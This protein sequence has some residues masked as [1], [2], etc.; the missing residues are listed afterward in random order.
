MTDYLNTLNK[1]QRIAAEH[2]DGPLLV[3]AG[4]GSG[5]TY[6]MTIRMKHLVEFHKINPASILGIT[7]TVKAANEMKERAIK[8]I[9]PKGAYIN[10]STFH[11]MCVKILRKDIHFLKESK[12]NKGRGY[13]SSFSILDPKDQL[14]I[15]KECMNELEI[16][17]KEYAPSAFLGYISTFKNELMNPDILE[18]CIRYADNPFATHFPHPPYIDIHKSVLMAQKVPPFIRNLVLAVYRRYMRKLVMMNSMDFDDL[19]MLTVRLFI[20]IPE[21]LGSY[22]DKFKYIMVDEYQDS[23]HAQY[24]LVKLLA[25]KHRNI[26]VVGDD[27]QCLIPSTKVNTPNGMVHIDQIKVGDLVEA[28]RGEF[29]TSFEK[30]TAVKMKEYGGNIIQVKTK[31]G[32]IVKGTPDHR[33]FSTFVTNKNDVYVVLFENENGYN[34]GTFNLEELKNLNTKRIFI[35]EVCSS[36]GEATYKSRKYENKSIESIVAETSLDLEYPHY[37]PKFYNG[38]PV[39][40]A[41]VQLASSMEENEIKHTY[42]LV[43]ALGKKTSDQLFSDYKSLQEAVSELASKQELYVQEKIVIDRKRLYFTPLS[44]LRKGMWIAVQTENGVVID[45][46]VDVMSKRYKGLVYDL[47]VANVHN[48]FANGVLVH[49]CIYGFRNA[50]LRNIL[51]F[52]KDYK[53]A[54]TVMLERNYRST[55]KILDRANKVISFNKHQRKKKLWTDKKGGDE[56]EYKV[57][58]DNY[59]EAEAIAEEIRKS[60]PYREYKD[61]AVLYRLNAQSRVLEEIFMRNGIPYTLVGSINFYDRREIKDVVSYLKVIVN[62]ADDMSLKRI[63]NVPKRG[64][65]K[66]TLEKIEKFASEENLT[67]WDA[68]VNAK[69][70]L[71]GNVTN[72]IA[73]FVQLISDLRDSSEVMGV[74]MIVDE[75]LESTGYKK[76]LELQ[77]TQ[78]AED[79]IENLNE[80]FNVAWEHQQEDED[81]SIISFLEKLSLSGAQESKDAEDDKQIEKDA[82]RLM[83]VHASKGLEFPVVFGIGMEENML[84]YYKAIAEDENVE[85]E[86]R[87]CYVLATRAKERLVFL[88]AKERR[89][90]NDIQ[91]NDPSRFLKE[92]GFEESET[93]GKKFVLPW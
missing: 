62:P 8:L 66:T 2:K 20:E 83:T 39:V 25:A 24:I 55:Q 51:E 87:L 52:E 14:N 12:K 33:T 75:V 7:F 13:D 72:K 82:V 43:S 78:E 1:D 29:G 45:E 6:T 19:I 58:E 93:E 64:I 47:D 90:F 46:I 3:L 15:V 73:D 44:N 4:A 34:V 56:V 79:R 81:P 40:T 48:Y 36:F 22:Q 41:E 28:S 89:V 84:P 53:E 16:D 27:F 35:L 86:R 54:R 88:R 85:E 80:F 92:M 31:S 63:I 9:G 17:T 68:L 18:H 42:S 60:Y 61:F 23:N 74:G 5:K 59:Q 11:S 69:K 21:V 76:D 91:M 37:I 67:F 77:K 30:V 57:C 32:Q 38:Q 70:F 65:G 49:N 71:T 50:D 26:A 10:L